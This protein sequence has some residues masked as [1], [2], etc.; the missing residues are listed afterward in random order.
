MNEVLYT[1]SSFCDR[2]TLEI[3][4]FTPVEI[5][6]LLQENF[7][8]DENG[9]PWQTY[10]GQPD[11]INIRALKPGQTALITGWIIDHRNLQNSTNLVVIK[12]QEFD[13]DI[14]IRDP[15]MMDEAARISN[16]DPDTRNVC[17]L[18]T[19]GAGE[20]EYTY[21]LLEPDSEVSQQYI[22]MQRKAQR[23]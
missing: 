2:A 1:H 10:Q 11:R 17:V 6:Q 13:D 14:W 16:L 18:I 3:W 23:K 21:E 22:D 8:F 20:E 5:N 4:G 7:Y 19:K 9:L 15:K 12:S